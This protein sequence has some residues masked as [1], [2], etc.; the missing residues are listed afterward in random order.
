MI[1]RYAVFCFFPSPFALL[2]L[3][4]F[5]GC[6]LWN[7]P[8]SNNL[9]WLTLKAPRSHEYRA[10]LSRGNI[11]I[12]RP[13][14]SIFDFRFSI[15]DFFGFSFFEFT[16]RAYPADSYFYVGHRS[17]LMVAPCAL[18]KHPP[19][20]PPHHAVCC[21]YCVCICG[22]ALWR[23]LARLV[24]SELVKRHPTH[25]VEVFCTT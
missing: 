22:L 16:A 17:L 21:A 15:F 1:A 14:A 12:W 4:Y 18:E 3:P 5:S 10:G 23:V 8:P 25:C 19:P 20:C 6:Y 11:E 9:W 2:P 13:S 24:P 7:R